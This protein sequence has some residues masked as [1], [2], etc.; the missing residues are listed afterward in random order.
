M[1]AA[2]QPQVLLPPGCR[3]GRCCS[4]PSARTHMLP[5]PGWLPCLGADTQWLSSG[6]KCS[7]PCCKMLVL[8][9]CVSKQVVVSSADVPQTSSGVHRGCSASVLKANGFETAS[10]KSI[11]VPGSSS[12]TVGVNQPPSDP[13]GANTGRGGVVAALFGPCTQTEGALALGAGWMDAFVTCS[14]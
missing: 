4:L 8:Q 7:C 2:L 5:P 11:A 6:A 1:A 3:M 9:V 13:E 14:L 10:F 12:P